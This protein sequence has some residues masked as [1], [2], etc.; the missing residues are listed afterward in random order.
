[1]K[2]MKIR[3]VIAAA[4]LGAIAITGVFAVST[5]GAQTNDAAPATSPRGFIKNLTQDQKD[6]LTAQGITRPDHRP[7]TE[8]REAL[9]TQLKAAA[10][11]CGITLPAPRAHGLRRRLAALTQDQKDCLKANGITRPDHRPTTEE[12]EALKTQLKAAA[13]TCGIP[14]PAGAGAPA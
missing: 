3:T 8:E 12:R 2:S 9:K 14:V 6:C 11:T 5:A 7:T 4:A 1:M 10:D 13:E